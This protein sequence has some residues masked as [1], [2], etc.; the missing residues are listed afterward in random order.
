M[1]R[2]G[3]SQLEKRTEIGH[4]FSTDFTAFSR[5]IVSISS[6][7]ND[8]ISSPNAVIRNWSSALD[9]AELSVGMQYQP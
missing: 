3:A 8:H 2:L 7:L 4:F 5:R 6:R 9:A 1:Q